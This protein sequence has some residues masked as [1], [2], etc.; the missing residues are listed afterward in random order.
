MITVKVEGI[1]AALRTL[2]KSLVSK[3]ASFAI[4]DSARQTRTE[5][6]AAIRARFN[7]AASRVNK[8]VKNLKASTRVDLTAVISAAGRPI[9]LPNFGARWVRNVKGAAR[10]TS[11]KKSTVGKRQAKTT[12]VIVRIEK[13]KTT[14]LP[15]AFMARGRRGKVDGAGAL[16]VFQRR[17][18]TRR[19]SALIDKATITIAT[20]MEQER[21]SARMIKKVNEVFGRRFDYHIDRLMK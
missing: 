18:L 13:N 7:I 16:R 9:G 12:G 11:A 10:T 1:E 8:E 19:D 6:S 3:A 17:D 21:V 20:M 15:N 4:N 14:V 5:A 2:D